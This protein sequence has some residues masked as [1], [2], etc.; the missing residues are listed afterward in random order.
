MLDFLD[1]KPALTSHWLL[2]NYSEEFLYKMYCSDF[3]K[4]LLNSP[5]RKDNN[6]SFSFYKRGRW[7]WK[8]LKTKE[9]G[10]IFDFIQK[11]ENAVDFK[12]TLEKVYDR[13]VKG[14][15][16][17][18]QNPYEFTIKPR[19]EKKLLQFVIKS[20]FEQID[21]QTWMRWGIAIAYLKT[22]HVGAAT[23]VFLNKDMIWSFSNQNPIYYIHFTKTNNVKG[24]RPLESDKKKKHIGVVNGKVDLYGLQEIKAENR[25]YR[26][27][28][29]TKAMKEVLF[30]RGFGIAAVS[31]CGEG[32]YFPKEIVQYL[33]TRCDHLISFYDADRAGY[34]G[35]WQLR[36]D[37]NIP[38][39][40]VIKQDGVKN[41]TD[42]WEHDYK[43]CY[44]Y[45]DAIL[46]WNEFRKE[47]A[48]TYKNILKL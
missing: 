23:K 16:H 21:I 40:F 29:I 24:Y 3:P 6:P 28:V 31:L 12:E 30:Y 1:I 35:A 14:N 45:I 8:D 43:K 27:I 37:Y 33:R 41:I 25:H 19:T 32:Y 46:N 42:L 7:L 20:D 11:M 34:H 9:G 47:K 17:F 39:M 26:V 18:S 13:L 4:N 48:L 15:Y 38:P 5:F 44:E 2:Q 36:K 10:G 22:F